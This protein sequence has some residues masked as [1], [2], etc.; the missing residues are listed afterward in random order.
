MYSRPNTWGTLC[1]APQRREVSPRDRIGSL[2]APSALYLPSTARTIPSSRPPPFRPTRPQIGRDGGPTFVNLAGSANHAATVG[3]KKAGGD[4][5]RRETARGSAGSR[6]WE[7]VR[8]AT[9]RAGTYGERQGLS[10]SRLGL[11]RARRTVRH[12]LG[13]HHG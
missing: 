3:K 12:W 13:R 4:G 11:I 7:R 8:Y 6:R 1:L 10:D 9:I 5:S 2:F